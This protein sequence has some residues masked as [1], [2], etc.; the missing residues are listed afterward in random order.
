MQEIKFRLRD[1]DNKILGY[2][3][4]KDGQW[5]YNFDDLTEWFQGF[6]YLNRIKYREQYLCLKD[7]NDKEIYENDY[8]RVFIDSDSEEPEEI[9]EGKLVLNSPLG[10]IIELIEGSRFLGMTY[11][12]GSKVKIVYLW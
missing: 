4:L 6:K 7:I 2:E 10:L 5:Y 9:L 12:C 1:K 8:V 3:Y 11:I